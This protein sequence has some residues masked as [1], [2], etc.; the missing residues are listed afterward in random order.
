M[1]TDPTY[2]DELRILRAANAQLMN[3]IEHV[4]DVAHEQRIRAL[5][6]KHELREVSFKTDLFV[7]TP[8][9]FTMI[10]Q[11]LCYS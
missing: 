10:F 2:D 8:I 11:A 4:K 9:S 5:D 7:F 6:L 3:E 1:Q